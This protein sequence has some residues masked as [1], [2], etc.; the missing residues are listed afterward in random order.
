MRDHKYS[1]RTVYD[2]VDSSSSERVVEGL[3]TYEEAWMTCESIAQ[4][5]QTLLVVERTE[6]TVK[7]GF[8]RDPD[9]H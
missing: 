7:P 3:S 6:Y 4:P 2:I 1:M 8:G 9:L 5:E